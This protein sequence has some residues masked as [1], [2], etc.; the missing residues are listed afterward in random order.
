MAD[1]QQPSGKQKA[2][3]LIAAACLVAAPV[4]ASFEGLRTHPYRDPAPK[5]TMTVCYGETQVKMNVYTPDECRMM[6]EADQRREYAPA[7]LKCTPGIGPKVNLFASA[8]D[9]AWN[10]G[11][12]NFCKS[13]M[14]AAFNRGA[15]AT[16]CNAYRGW[17]VAPGGK[18]LPGLVRRRETERTLCLKDAK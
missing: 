14:A 7:V 10:A 5:H 9:A 1:V 11:P 12:S 17:H 2:A 15:W 13:P 6:L 16:G 3:A 4:T 18:L 8:I